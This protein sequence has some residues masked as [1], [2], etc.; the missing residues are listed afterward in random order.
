VKQFKTRLTWGITNFR[1]TKLRTSTRM[2]FPTTK[3]RR[4]FKWQSSS[5]TLTTA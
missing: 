1:K 2:P 5:Q 4:I 3:K